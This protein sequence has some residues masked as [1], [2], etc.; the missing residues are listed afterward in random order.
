MDNMDNNES[1]EKVSAS[2][3]ELL[4]D[5]LKDEKKKLEDK[6]DDKKDKKKKKKETKGTAKKLKHGTMATILTCVFVALVVLL[7]VVTTMIFDRYLS[8]KRQKSMSRALTPMCS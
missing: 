7:N 1:V 8:P 5:V 3:A 2:S 4:A 6:A